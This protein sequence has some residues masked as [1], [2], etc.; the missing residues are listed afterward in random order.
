M[1]LDGEISLPDQNMEIL[2]TLHYISTVIERIK[3]PLGTRENPARVCKDLL[4]CHYKLDD[5][6]RFTVLHHIQSKN[7]RFNVVLSLDFIRLVLD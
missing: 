7:I 4:D 1:L 6:G 3:K 2:K 5:G